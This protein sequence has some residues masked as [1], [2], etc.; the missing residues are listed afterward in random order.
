MSCCG[1]REKYN[2]AKNEQKWDYINLS[3]F[4][5]TSC[6]SPLSYGFLII[7]GIIS[8]AVYAVDIFTCANLLLYNR[9]SGQ[10]KPVIP[11]RYSK[12]IFTACII[13]SWVLLVYR[14]QRAIRVMK[15][16]VVAAS[17]LDPLAVR[18]QSIR[19]GANGRGWRRF[20][21]FAALT[22]GRKGAEYVALFSYFSFEAWMRICFAEGPRQAI[23]ALTLYS[24][25]RAD[26][27]PTG[28]HAAKD[29][30]SPVAQF[31]VNIKILAGTQKEQAAIL[32]GMLFTL[33]IWVFSA[34]SLMLAVIFYIVFLWHHI[35]EGS[36][37]KYCRRK[38]DSRLH[39]IVMVKVNKALEK[40]IKVR[41]KQEGNGSGPNKIDEHVKRQPTLPNLLSGPPQD[42]PPL[43]RQ[44]TQTEF[45]P[46]DSRPSTPL[47]NQSANNLPREPT[48][49][50]VFATAQRPQPPSRATTQ[51]SMRSDMSYGD[52]APLMASAG[53]MGYGR[54][55]SRNAPS[56]MDSAN[57][58]PQ[59]RP[60]PSRSFTGGSQGTQRSFDPSAPRMGPPPRTNTDLGGRITPAAYTAQPEARKPMPRDMSFTGVPGRP[61][62]STPLSRRPTQEYEMQIQPPMNRPNGPS[63]NSG[64]VAFRPNAQGTGRPGYP[65]SATPSSSQPPT[66]NFTLPHRPPQN[67]YFGSDTGVPQRSGT[68]PIPE[69]ASF[70]NIQGRA[71][72]GPWQPPSADPIHNRPATAGPNGQRGPMPHRF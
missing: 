55:G 5:S 47:N 58:L 33:V 18:V 63:N 62:G 12:W 3:D 8:V 46:F 11:F 7:L 67:E 24:V 60:P 39:K 49:P 52:D 38:I 65:N 29:G 17:Y 30:Q 15:G 50:N 56:R 51:S 59:S 14:W 35:R 6:V 23:N 25:M 36:L 31:F 22:K 13:L 69:A 57:S 26:L 1:E 19:M 20:L 68:A 43:S 70:N 16:G 32:F 9:W 61:A 2:E 48:I 66:R 54:P 21:V 34:I 27:V 40:D 71:Y 10:V 64:Y 4:R 44:T 45:S 72:G 41:G 28:S 42:T 37:S 53:A